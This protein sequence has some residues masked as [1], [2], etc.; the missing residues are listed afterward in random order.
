MNLAGA[1]QYTVTTYTSDVTL[2]GTDGDVFFSFV[3]S[4]GATRE[5][6]ADNDWSDREKGKVDTDTFSDD[7]EI[8]EFQC[9]V[10]KLHC[11]T[12]DV[13]VGWHI[14]EVFLS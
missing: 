13:F 10:V 6:K 5:Y 1:T 7:T 3:G 11:T 8:G 14:K 12:F 2:A 9:V 4:E